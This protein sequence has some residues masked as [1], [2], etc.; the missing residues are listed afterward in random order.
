MVDADHRTGGRNC[1][2]Q[3]GQV[4]A[5]AAADIEDGVARLQLQRR[6]CPLLVLLAAARRGDAAEV[7]AGMRQRMGID[8]PRRR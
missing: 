7:S 1:F 2:G 5:R 8:R 3:D 4:R 6:Q